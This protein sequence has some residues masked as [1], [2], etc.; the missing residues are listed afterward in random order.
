MY[1]Q[2]PE[3]VEHTNGHGPTFRK[4]V[5]GAVNRVE[6]DRGLKYP[7]RDVDVLGGRCAND[8]EQTVRCPGGRVL[9]GR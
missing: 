9:P 4:C 7:R 2:F 6:I 8:D 5:V 3:V 1:R